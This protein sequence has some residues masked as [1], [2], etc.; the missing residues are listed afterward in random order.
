MALTTL[1]GL[2]A[3]MRAAKEV[4]VNKAAIGSTIQGGQASLWR[5]TGLPGQ[6]AIPGAAAVCNNSLAGCLELPTRTGGQ[7]RV[8]AWAEHSNSLAGQG[9]VIEDRL[10]HMGGLS[11]TVTTAQTANVDISL[12][13]SNLEARIGGSNVYTQCTWWLEWYTATGA[14]VTTPTAQVTYHDG[15]TDSC[16]I[17]NLGTTALPASVAA[18]RRYQIIPNSGKY[19]K[20]VQTVTLSASTGTAGSFGVTATRQLAHLP[21]SALIYKKEVADWAYLAAQ[22]V[23]DSACVSFSMYTLTTTTGVVDAAIKMAVG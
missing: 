1:D 7:H 21:A 23:E 14:T 12:T 13:T 19:I 15:T 2:F 17:N 8:L 6:G 18:S 16:N 5:A 11:G 10:A 3:A 22:V 20:S 4:Q 9:L